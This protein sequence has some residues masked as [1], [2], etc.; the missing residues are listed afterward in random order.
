MVCQ[1]LEKVFGHLE[2][3]LGRFQI[4]ENIFGCLENIL[5]HFQILLG[6]FFQMQTLLFAFSLEIEVH[7]LFVF[8]ETSKL[9]ATYCLLHA[10]I[11]LR[12]RA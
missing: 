9:H 7:V 5:G 10:I 3:I 6:R 11:C 1:I 12:V 8:S 2:N 4:L